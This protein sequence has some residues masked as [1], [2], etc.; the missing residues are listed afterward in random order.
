MSDPAPA[1]P[2]LNP[3]QPGLGFPEI[4]RAELAPT[5]DAPAAR[6][7][8]W[9]VFAAIAA[10]FTLMI[11]VNV[12]GVVA[13]VVV[14]VVGGRSP[15]ELQEPLLELITSPPGFIGIGLPTQM[16]LVAVALAAA[17]LSPQPMSRRLGFV[18]PR[19]PWWQTLV[20]NLGTLVPF[21]IGM[22]AAVALAKV[23]E[24]DPTA[25]N[26]MKTMTPAWIVP[27][28]LFIS[29]APG[30]SEEMLFRG[31]VQRRLIE[32]WGG[33]TAVLVTSAIFAAIHIAPHTVVFAFP[34]GIWLGLM[35]WRSGSIWP[36]V[37]AHAAVNG[38]WNAYNIAEQFG[39]ISEQPSWV[40]L[41]TLGAVGVVAFGWS[42]RI[43]F[44]QPLQTTD[45][46]ASLAVPAP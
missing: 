29:L 34:V 39:F 22:C 38:L 14:L 15:A 46:P 45:T 32:R 35:A 27:Y 7:R 24:P 37:I 43:M 23:L 4:I 33:W 36:G 41:G 6:P 44:A 12:F 31:Y 19:W 1:Q 40:F 30:F 26:L 18:R 13:L 21:A 10:A 25:A 5:W 8:V 11:A 2:P 16:S 17:W 9:T 28:L 42:L 3:Y 20:V